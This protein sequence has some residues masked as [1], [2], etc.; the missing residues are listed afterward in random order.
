M[1]RL[2]FAVLAAALAAPASAQDA[3][4]AKISGPVSVLAE[5]GA[6]FV[7]AKGGEQLLFGDTI[8]VGKGGIAHVILAERGAVL[9]REE[10]LLTLQGSRRRT[11]LAVKFGEFLI[12][13]S[14][15]LERGESFKVRTPAAVAAVRGTLFWGKSDKA[16]QS[17]AYAGFGHVV[18]VTAKGK[19]VLVEPGRTVTVAFGAPPSDA[20]PSTVG[21]DYAK[22]FMIDGSLQGAEALAETDKLKK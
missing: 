18:A 13:L 6:R 19:T 15:T 1:N 14:G 16:D 20:V 4:L 21:L 5:G 8:R 17:T 2:A 12:G 3:T 7:K 9:L 11:T 10:S 22:N